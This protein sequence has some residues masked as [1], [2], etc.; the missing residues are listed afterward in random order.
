MSLPWWARLA[1]TFAGFLSKEYLCDLWF[2][3]GGVRLPSHRLI[4]AQLGP[5]SQ[6]SPLAEVFQH[7]QAGLESSHYNHKYYI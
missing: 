3:C 2:I 7:S 1:P 6:N 5:P 4:L